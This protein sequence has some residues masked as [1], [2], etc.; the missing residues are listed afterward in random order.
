MGPSAGVVN[1]RVNGLLFFSWCKTRFVLCYTNGWLQ[2]TTNTAVPG[3]LAL[4][5]SKLLPQGAIKIEKSAGKTF[6]RATNDGGQG[7]R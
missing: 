2:Y 7:A 6:S 5:Y 4:P 1:L 3:A